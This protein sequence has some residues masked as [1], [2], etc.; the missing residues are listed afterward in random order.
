[1]AKIEAPLEALRKFI[2]EKS[3]DRVSQYLF[4]HSIHL[5]ITKARSTILGDYRNAAQG[6]NHRISINGNLNPYAF[7]YTLIHEIAHLL[8]FEQYAHRVAAHGPEWKKQFS[9]LLRDFLTDEIFP[10]DIRA[11]IA[12]SLRNPAASSCAEEGL[13]RIFRKYDQGKD[14]FYFVEELEQGALFSLKDGRIFRR[15]EKIRKRFKCVEVSTSRQYL[16]SPVY[17]V[18]RIDTVP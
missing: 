6:R 7:L 11:A 8:V 12:S 16:F 13:L 14:D 10:E 2:P 17:E 15:G 9:S 5:T 18:K 3:F 4:Q 1:M